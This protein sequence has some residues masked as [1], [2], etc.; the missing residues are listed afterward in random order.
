MKFQVGDLVEGT[1]KSLSG[2][3]GQVIDVAKEGRNYKYSVKWYSECNRLADDDDDEN[4]GRGIFSNSLKKKD[5]SRDQYFYRFPNDWNS[6]TTTPSGS[7]SEA[8]T[9]N[10]VTEEEE[11]DIQRMQIDQLNN[12]LKRLLNDVFFNGRDNKRQ[13]IDYTEDMEDL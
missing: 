1:S 10:R 9:P 3:Y 6:G 8:T 5:L 2:R 4:V 11:R 13:R 7:N 12:K